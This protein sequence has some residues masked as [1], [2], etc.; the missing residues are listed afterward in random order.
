MNLI[1]K[2]LLVEVTAAQICDINL[3][4]AENGWDACHKCKN[5]LTTF[6][7]A[8]INKSI[9][10]VILDGKNSADWNI[11]FMSCVG[12]PGIKAKTWKENKV[13]VKLFCIDY[14]F[15]VLLEKDVSFFNEKWYSISQFYV[16]Y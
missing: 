1:D 9:I 15:C 16:L 3:K 4:S 7:S 8:Q 2:D 13:I 14:L 11:A 10:M 5:I 12:S 6:T